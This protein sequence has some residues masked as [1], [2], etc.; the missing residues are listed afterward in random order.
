MLYKKLTRFCIYLGPFFFLW[1]WLF[2]GSCSSS[3]YSVNWSLIDASI[4]CGGNASTFRLFVTKESLKTTRDLEDISSGISCICRLCLGDTSSTVAFSSGSR[5]SSSS[6]SSLHVLAM[7][8][9]GF[10]LPMVEGIAVLWRE[11][12][13]DSFFLASVSRGKDSFC[14]PCSRFL[15]SCARRSMT[16]P[17]E[18]KLY[19]VFLR[20]VTSLDWS[21]FY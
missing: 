20:Y 19:L 6:L 4:C 9:F 14:W 10:F 1:A 15:D 2:R 7:W 12:I 13:L 5:L 18:F 3:E 17:K 16:L 11:F 8:L 21:F